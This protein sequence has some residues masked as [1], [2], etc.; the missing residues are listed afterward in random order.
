VFSVV[1]ISVAAVL[2]W[3]LWSIPHPF[4]LPVHLFFIAEC[5]MMLPS[6]TRDLLATIGALAVLAPFVA[7]RYC[8][9]RWRAR[10]GTGDSAYDSD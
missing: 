6:V 2:R 1:C 8:R 3:L 7:W 5:W 4:A 10:F 9:K